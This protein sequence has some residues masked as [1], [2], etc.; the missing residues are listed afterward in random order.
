[1]SFGLLPNYSWT[2]HDRPKIQISQFSVDSDVGSATEAFEKAL[3]AGNIS[4]I[5][6]T[7]IAQAKTEEE[8]ADWK[9]IETLIAENPRKT[10]HRI[11]WILR[12]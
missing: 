5:C 11:S 3:V 1:M 9:V 4:S 2:S 10:C 6:E 8:K 12:R 7:H